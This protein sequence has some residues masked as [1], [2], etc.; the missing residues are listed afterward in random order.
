MGGGGALRVG[1][2]GVV[3]PEGRPPDVEVVLCRLS[4]VVEPPLASEVEEAR[5][6]CP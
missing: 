3:F 4:G 5:D 6:R 1:V 2:V